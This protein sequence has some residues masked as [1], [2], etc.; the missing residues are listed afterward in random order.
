M[1]TTLCTDY[2]LWV[3]VHT[4]FHKTSLNFWASPTFIPYFPLQFSSFIYH[5]G[6]LSLFL[7][8]RKTFSFKGGMKGREEYMLVDTWLSWEEAVDNLHELFCSVSQSKSEGCS[9]WKASLEPSIYSWEQRGFQRGE[10]TSL[11]HLSVNDR[12]SWTSLTEKEMCW[13][14]NW[15]AVEQHHLQEQLDSGVQI[16]LPKYLVSSFCSLLT[17][18]L[19]SFFLNGNQL[20]LQ[21]PQ[22]TTSAE[23]VSS[24]TA[25]SKV[26]GCMSWSRVGHVRIPGEH[27]LAVISWVPNSCS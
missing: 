23:N 14:R 26:P 16:M 7:A 20:T 22:V 27:S 25:P 9:K 8:R 18:F 10:V 4:V 17:L 5:V 13:L 3:R 6:W 12:N 11:T 1:S 21:Q 24:L 2:T 19:H 15:K